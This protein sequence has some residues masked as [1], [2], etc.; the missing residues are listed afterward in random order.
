MNQIINDLINNIID[1]SIKEVMD[2]QKKEDEVRAAIRA[3]RGPTRQEI[4][5]NNF[6]KY[7]YKPIPKRD[8]TWFDYQM[9]EELARQERLRDLWDMNPSVDVDDFNA[10][11]QNGYDNY[12]SDDDE[13]Y[14]YE[15]KDNYSDNY[16]D[17]YGYEEDQFYNN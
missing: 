5:I 1:E 16:N 15:Y 17:Y 11:Y 8:W 13:E 3:Y 14:Q 12:E 4:F 2:E 10:R 7:G 9:E 6:K